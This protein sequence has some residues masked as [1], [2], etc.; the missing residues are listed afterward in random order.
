MDMTDQPITQAQQFGQIFLGKKCPVHT[1]QKHRFFIAVEKEYNEFRYIDYQHFEL[2][3]HIWD[4]TIYASGHQ[5]QYDPETRLFAFEQGLQPPHVL[6]VKL[7]YLKSGQTRLSVKFKGKW[8]ALKSFLNTLMKSIPLMPFSYGDLSQLW[9]ENGKSFRLLEL[10][11][12]L[13]DTIYKE[14]LLPTSTVVHA[15]Q[16]SSKPGGR[17]MRNRMWC[18]KGPSPHNLNLIAK[19]RTGFGITP[20]DIVLPFGRG[21]N[22]LT[23]G[24]GGSR[25][26]CE[27]ALEVL[28]PTAQFE[29]T[30]LSQLSRFHKCVPPNHWKMIK[31]MKFTFCHDEM[32]RMLGAKLKR[33]C[34]Y[35]ICPAIEEI[36]IMKLRKLTIQFPSPQGMYNSDIELWKPLIGGCQTRIVQVMLDLLRPFVAHLSEKQLGLE[37]FIKPAQTRR[38]FSFLKYYESE[39]EVCKLPLEFFQEDNN[40][41]GVS[42]QR[43]PGSRGEFYLGL[44]AFSESRIED[45]KN[46]YD[47]EDLFPSFSLPPECKCLHA[48]TLDVEDFHRYINDDDLAP[49]DEEKVGVMGSD[50]SSSLDE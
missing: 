50:S 17:R 20:N 42:L 1:S 37:G 7:V 28:Y 16:Y 27:E 38:F 6:L 3:L 9:G 34:D 2:K 40:E 36:P 23:Q 10:P 19:R 41:G 15:F 31:E 46:E 44:P 39:P 48:C 21:Y 11:R 5:Y 32:L 12:E 26:V 18:T 49:K 24:N 43:L 29:L 30:S 33:G 4:A 45:V 47:P 25:Q 14:S 35:T 22:T 13:R 8:R